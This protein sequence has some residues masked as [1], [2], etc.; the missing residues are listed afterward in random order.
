[1]AATSDW[2]SG[3]YEISKII[4][5]TLE[6]GEIFN[7]IARE[8]RRL[9]DF[10]RLAMG[11]LE[12]SGQRLRMYVPV[13]PDGTCR[14][15]GASIGLDGHVLGAVIRTRKPLALPDLRAETRFPGDK[16]LVDEGLISCVALPL[17]SKNRPL[18]ALA[19]ARYRAEPFA[20]AEVEVLLHV[21]EQTATAVD[22][23]YLFAAEKKRANH[24]AI[25]NEVA[26]RALSTFDLDTLLQ[27][28][29]SLI[30]RHFA[31]YDVSVFLADRH[32]DEVVLRAQAGAYAATSAVGYRQP[33][34]VGMVGWAAK[35]GKTLLA[36]DVA[37]DPHYIMAFEGERASRSELAVPIRIGG[38]VVGII[39][40]EC[41]EV[42]AFDQIDVTA[43]ETLSDQ[44][45]QAIENARLYEEMRYL[46]ELDESIL[47]S[48][49]SSIL[50]IDRNLAILTVNET[51]CRV[52]G[53]SREE[54][55][56]ESAE[57]FLR[58]EALDPPSFRRTIEHV[59]DADER[60]AFA[61]IRMRLPDG[62]ER[63]V[64]LHL[65]P[66]ARR[67]QRRALVFINDITERRR[68]EEEVRREKQKLD[69][70]VSAMNAGLVLIDHD[71]D[72]VWSN[73]T[74]NDWFGRGR[75]VV[76]QKCHVVHANPSTPCTNCKARATLA[77][78][79]VQTDTQIVPSPQ[80]VRHYQNIFA[81]IRD[82]SGSVVQILMLAFDVTDHTRNV[83]QIGL[84]QKLSEAMQGTLELDRLL[85]LILTCVT[86]GPG[87]GFNR[88]ILLLV[89][90]K[91]TVL[92]G[93][94]GVGPA[95]ADE[96][97][98]I[99]RE[100][101][102]RAQTLENLLALFDQPHAAGDSAMQYLTQQIRIPLAE[103]D[104]VPVR[105]LREKRP[106]V[107]TDADT[108]PGVS[109]H[110]RS[111]LRAKHFVCVP[112]IARDVG[113]GAIL[114]DNVFTGRPVTEHDVEMLKTFA[115]HAGLAI[116]AASAYKRLEE[117]LN[118][119][120]ETHDR[121]VG[122]E[123]L[124]VIGRLAAHV[125]HEIRNPLATIGGFARSM[126]RSADD[127]RK[128]TRNAK[129]I[130]EEV[131]RLEHILANVMNFTKPGNPVL[132]ERNINESVESICAFHE[133][134]FAE[135]RITLGK[136][137]DSGCPVLRFDPDQIRQVLINLCQ[138][139][140]D[141]MPNGGDLTIMTRTQEDH[142]EIVV[143]DTGH[144]MSEDV[145]ENLFQPFFTTKP[146]GT[147]LGLSVCQ[148][149]IHDHGGDILVRSKPGAG[150]SLT[151]CLPI[152]GDESSQETPHAYH[153]DR[154]R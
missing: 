149:I 144:G 64:D 89:N 8:T 30:Q 3:M 113:L 124:A 82:A 7:V 18:G 63:I 91:Q 35:T 86:A 22:H 92:E 148:K 103:A 41:T 21:A 154:R 36:N 26:K 136:S 40:V 128:I 71:L 105:A 139:A 112:L 33:I 102:E 117:Q 29:A 96:A 132:R 60:A 31:Y 53:R 111:L 99:W 145:L 134:V 57:R 9:V 140:I 37:H 11:L 78:G 34:G 87:L 104:Q 43:L 62:Q 94:L 13:A 67:T 42:G 141:S 70:V 66:V 129:I 122:S 46:K 6:L 121:L 59:I 16:P 10:D 100:L 27:Q 101:S 14:P 74:I 52:L 45:A 108:H 120:E 133:N 106:I 51:A 32:A 98:R 143:A 137:L 147:G 20:E 56:S 58:F 115:T 55:I 25:I 5:A 61:A 127:G 114:A 2:L 28:T 85:H 77:T 116:S 1:M 65:S 69:E 49:P 24:L 4:N 131:E 142:V 150:S 135:R 97:S 54:L 126:L 44:V 73:R 95:S 48:I 118:E 50:V 79:D 151:V 109:P 130:L 93:R 123:R 152:P 110:L 23:A 72:I 39:N 75:T 76:G 17:I 15:S 83:E 19:F 88:A 81:P 138:N 47:A 38:E 153:S 125:A 90:D 80:G 12:E 84:L 146:G 68:A 119:L 107:V